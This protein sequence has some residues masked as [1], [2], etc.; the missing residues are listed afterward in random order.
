MNDSSDLK[1]NSIWESRRTRSAYDNVSVLIIDDGLSHS[2]TEED[3]THL[4]CID[5]CFVHHCANLLQCMK[6]LKKTTGREYI[7]VLFLNF[8]KEKVQAMIC[9]LGQ[10]EQL[11]AFFIMYPTGHTN[12]ITCE[13][14][15]EKERLPTHEDERKIT[16][17]FS[18]WQPLLTTVQQFVADTENS[19]P[20]AGLFTTC[21]STEKALRDVGRE[22]GSLVWTNTFRGRYHACSSFNDG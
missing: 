13:Q 18:E 1:N 21:N 4:K 7:I 22:L 16:K 2:Y 8:N 19:L 9:Q 20:D 6:Y 11:R 3:K 5:Y 17:S 12:D 10:Y 15:M 14:P